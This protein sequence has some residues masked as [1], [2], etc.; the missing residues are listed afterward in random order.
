MPLRPAFTSR[1]ARRRQPPLVTRLH[2]TESD[3]ANSRRTVR[4]LRGFFSSRDSDRGESGRARQRVYDKLFEAAPGGG[5]GGGGIRPMPRSRSGTPVRAPRHLQHL[6]GRE[7]AVGDDQ[8]DA[9]YVPLTTVHRCELSK[10][11]RLVTAKSLPTPPVSKDVKTLM[12][13][14]KHRRGRPTTSLSAPA[15]AALGK[16]GTRRW[17]AP[18]PATCRGS[19]AARRLDTLERSRRTMTALLASVASIPWVGYRS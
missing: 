18:L 17:R 7:G 10:L 15:S 3:M 6:M 12:R 13:D 8:F 19:K 14:A 2:C 16:G 5:G 4:S 1:P 9:I 11:N